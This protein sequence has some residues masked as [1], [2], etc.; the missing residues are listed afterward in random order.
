MPARDIL[1]VQARFHLQMA[2]HLLITRQWPSQDIAQECTKIMHLQ[3]CSPSL[4]SGIV[5]ELLQISSHV[6]QAG[7]LQEREVIQDLARR[8]ASTFC[9]IPAWC[10]CELICNILPSLQSI[11]WQCP[12][13]KWFSSSDMPAQMSWV[14]GKHHVSLQ[15]TK[16]PAGKCSSAG[17]HCTQ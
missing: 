1:R 2:H 16:V 9:K 12:C 11:K 6:H 10:K 13:S 17:H 8:S 7:T 14:K 4:K 15:N 3:R 5:L